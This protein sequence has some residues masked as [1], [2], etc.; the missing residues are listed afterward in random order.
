MANNTTNKTVAVTGDTVH[1]TIAISNESD[2]LC[3]DASVEFTIPDGIS[4]SGPS[5]SGSSAI[6]VER[7]AF[8]PVNDIW[9]VGKMNPWEKVETNFIIR[10]DNIDS[11]DPDLG[12]FILEALATSSCLEENCC[13]N[14]TFLVLD[15]GEAPD[16]AD[17]S[18][19]EEEQPSSDYD[20]SLG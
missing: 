6:N 8:D 3:Y 17:I 15:I 10:V 1:W 16:C 13:D 5:D 11:V 19:G 12:K 18:I 9:H 4:I 14:T 7:G 20:I 2:E